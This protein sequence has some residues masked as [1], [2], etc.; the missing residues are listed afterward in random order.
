MSGQQGVVRTVAIVGGGV[1]GIAAAVRAAD[2]GWRPV[3]I[4]TRTRLGGRAM[5]FD[6]VRSGVEL[7]NC[8]HVVM[9]CCTNILEL[10]DRLGVLDEL[11]WHETLWF[12][13]G[14][15]LRDR[16][17]I[18]PVLPAPLH[19]APSFLRMKLFGLAEKLAIARAFAAILR[20]GPRGRL[21]WQGRAFGEFLAET[22]QP[23]RVVELFWDPVVVSACNL[24]SARCE[25]AHALK[26]FDEGMLAHRFAGAV[27]VARVPLSRL[28]EGVASIVEG[29]GGALRL[30]TSAKALAFDG[31]RVTGVVCDDGVVAAQAVISAVTPD[32]LARLCSDTLRAHDKRLAHLDAFGFSP[33]LGVHIA[34]RRRV[35]EVPNLALPGRTVHWLFAHDAPPGAGFAQRIEA[36]VSAADAWI[37]LS[38][39]EVEARVLAEIRWAI[40]DA[41]RDDIVWSRPVLEKRATFASAPGIDAIRPRARVEAGDLKGGVANLFLAGEWTDTGWPSTMEGAARSG[42]AAAAACCGGRGVEGDLPT[43][44]LVRLARAF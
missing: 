42:F 19:Y 13:R 6:D 39:A 21:R 9:G 12:A 44:A 41:T 1:A 4:E 30:R 8:Q 25:A 11:D 31:T 29:A 43:A 17:A 35:M 10:Y 24:P 37:G 28:Y 7:D 20:M 34:L 15:G 16:L 32:R 36:V 27:G 26:V 2:A 33:I 23:A 40:P 18:A 14:N 5:S 38:E 3:L 22:R